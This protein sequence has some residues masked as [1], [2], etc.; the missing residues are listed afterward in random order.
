MRRRVVLTSGI[1]ILMLCEDIGE[2]LR[3]H[4]VLDWSDGHTQIGLTLVLCGLALRSWAVGIL[5]KGSQLTT[6]GPYRNLRNPLYAGSFL[7]MLGFAAIIDDEENMWVILGPLLAL[8]YFKV[9]E[10]ERGLLARFGDQW[11]SYKQSTPRLFPRRFSIDRSADWQGSQWMRSR[12]YRAVLSAL[13][14]FVA[15]YVW[16]CC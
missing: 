8:Y 16:R 5:R 14:G 2:G 11:T 1:I 13:C 6:T 15:L 4:N 12:E 10:E 7:M 3:P 9:R